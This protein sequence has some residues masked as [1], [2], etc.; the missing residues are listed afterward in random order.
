[1]DPFNL[2][3]LVVTWLMMLAVGLAIDGKDLPGLRRRPTLVGA[4][5]VVHW[6]ILPLLALTIARGLGLDR[7]LTAAL[8]LLAACP[9]GDI[10]TFYTLVG[11]GVVPLAVALNALSC[12]LAPVG[13]G[14]VFAGLQTAQPDE[15]P[16]HPPGWSLVL[17]VLLLALV[18]IALG[19]LIRA[20]WPGW[21]TRVL[22]P[23][24]RL[25][26]AGI[27]GVLAWALVRQRGHLAAIWAEALPAVIAFLAAGLALGIL[28]ARLWRLP[29]AETLPVAVTFPVRN[30][31][32]AA[33]LAST[34]MGRPEYLS[35]FALY[36]FLEVPIFLLGA[37]LWRDARTSE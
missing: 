22:P 1:M 9:V 12:L 37:R 33:A 6:L 21:S 27:I 8:L 13:M 29:R 4:T 25:A 11:R 20:R 7:E 36:F 3:I 5:L 2:S 19:L 32:L 31:G 14:L 18:P 35:L 15:L 23:C 10:V 34:L 24:A 30:V 28:W 17:R 26:G 16:L